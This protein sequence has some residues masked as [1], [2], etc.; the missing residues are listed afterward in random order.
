V[1]PLAEALVR[2]PGQ[3]LDFQQT[4]DAR[5]SIVNDT[6]AS[7]HSVVDEAKS[8]SSQSLVFVAGKSIPA[9]NMDAKDQLIGPAWDPAVNAE[10]T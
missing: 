7:T 2:L 4:I 9:V 5:V 10:L 3:T 8:K 1:I 6:A